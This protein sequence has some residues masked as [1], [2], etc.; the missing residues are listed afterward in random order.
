MREISAVLE[1]VHGGDV[2]KTARQVNHKRPGRLRQNKPIF[3]PVD[4]GLKP[5]ICQSRRK[6]FMPQRLQAL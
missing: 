4:G 3:S 2:L 5:S 1:S 6:R